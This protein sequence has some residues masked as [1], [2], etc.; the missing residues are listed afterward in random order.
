MSKLTHHK[1]SRVEE[2]PIEFLD[3]YKVADFGAEK[4]GHLN[5]LEPNGSKSSHKDMHASIFRHIAASS[6]GVRLDHETGL[7][8]LLH[9]QCRIAM[10]YTR[11][12]RGIKHGED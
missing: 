1:I 9:A 7:D 5:F 8:H 10:L 4:H 6:A 2:Y 12:T 11:I 3:F